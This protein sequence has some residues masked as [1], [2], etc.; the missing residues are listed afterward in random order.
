L[1]STRQY[2]PRIEDGSERRQLFHSGSGSHHVYLSPH[3]SK[4]RREQ[5]SAHDPLDH[6]EGNNVVWGVSIWRPDADGLFG[7][8]RAASPHLGR[9]RLRRF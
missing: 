6:S 8:K 2:E 7:D 4:E 5:L 3:S 9:E 1:D